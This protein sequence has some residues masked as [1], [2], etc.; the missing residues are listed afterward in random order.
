MSQAMVSGYYNL[1][2]RLSDLRQLRT[3]AVV[4]FV[5]LALV[6]MMGSAFAGTGGTQFDPVFTWLND[7]I[8]GGLGRAIV[9]AGLIG[10]VF[11]AA[12]RQQP[13]LAMSA[14][15]LALIVGFGPG[16]VTSFVTGTI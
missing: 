8:T 2:A 5:V 10:G 4:G 7:S 16:I 14:A 13:M 3:V 1:G 12:G 9:V 11:A 15:V 6:F